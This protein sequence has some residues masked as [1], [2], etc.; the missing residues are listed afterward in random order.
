MTELLGRSGL[1][2]EQRDIAAVI[3]HS[4][5]SLDSIV[6]DILEFS[7]VEA[8]GVEV[9][10]I[11]FEARAI[12]EDAVRFFAPRARGKGIEIECCIAADVSGMAAGD[13][14][15]IRRVLMNLVSNAIKFTETGSVRVEVASAGDPE[16]GQALLFRVIDTGIGIAPQVSRRLFHAFTQADSGAARKFSGAGW[17]SPFRSAW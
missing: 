3:L 11:P 4:S 7:K 15:H 10:H 5:E 17:A 16:E 13:P 2:P 14:K 9:E 6:S 12:A 8:G 1:S